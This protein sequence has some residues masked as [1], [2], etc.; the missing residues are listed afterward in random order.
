MISVSLNHFARC[1]ATTCFALVCT[2]GVFAQ[3]SNLDLLVGLGDFDRS[4]RSKLSGLGDLGIEPT[5]NCS[6][7]DGWVA[8][9]DLQHRD[10]YILKI[11]NATNYTDDGA[12]H[13][14]PGKNYQYIGINNTS[15]K[16]LLA[17]FY[18]LVASNPKIP[19]ET[20]QPGD[21]YVFSIDRL[22]ASNHSHY[23]APAVSIGVFYK[24]SGSDT[25][26]KKSISLNMS[27]GYVDKASFTLQEPNVTFV[28]P[29]VEMAVAN[30][31]LPNKVPAILI[32][33]ARL[34]VKRSGS[35]DYAAE[36]DFTVRNRSINVA[37]YAWDYRNTPTRQVAQSFDEISTNAQHYIQ[38]LQLK[39]LNPNVKVYLY[40]S[41]MAACYSDSEP[42]WA[43][44]PFKIQDAA[45]DNPGWLWP[46]SKP[47]A[48]ND[49]DT[50]A[51]IAPD[52]EWG[53]L[54]A[55]Y[56]NGSGYP[57]RFWIS[58]V[59]D[60]AYQAEWARI[61][62]DKAKKIGV[63]GVWIDD[64]ATLNGSLDRDGVWR[65]PWEVQQFLHGIIPKL[66]AAGLTVVVNSALGLLDGSDTW[67]GVAETYFNPFW[68][69]TSSRPA[70]A[71]YLENTAANTPD[72]FFR[73]Y[74]F[75]ING[76][77]YSP[78]YWLKCLNDAKIV[79]QWN[80]VLADQYKKRIHYHI[81]ERDTD[82]HPAYDRNG[83]PGWVPFVLAS[84]L[85][86]N[87]QYV[88]FCPA[89][90]DANGN[91]TAN[92]DVSITKRLGV[93]DGDDRPVDTDPYFRMRR[94]KSDGAGSF[95]GVVVVNA[96][97]AVSKTYT[98]DFGATDESGNE[99]PAGTVITLKPNSGRI[100]LKQ[101]T[102]V[103]V[104][105]VTASQN[106]VP[107]QVVDVSVICRNTSASSVNDV[108]VRAVVPD[109]TTYVPGS[110]EQSGGS[111]DAN[112]NTVSWL[113]PRLAAGATVTQTFRVTVN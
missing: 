81:G 13:L 109:K 45:R 41:G 113:V 26:H 18:S 63:D 7:A 59:A 6:L 54:I 85:L 29:Y 58:N 77:N 49:P 60:S 34:W 21:R 28:R 51:G 95:G 91:I 3:Q 107:K 73:E 39:K 14:K 46:Q 96:N 106:V 103:S 99:V 64:C 8:A 37:G 32:S 40:Q 15:G 10:K 92:I 44:A 104:Q 2:S 53:K 22:V 112:S 68:K 70:S 31:T 67:Q 1:I 88:S 98:V 36:A 57:D 62:I 72:V 94:Y 82:A 24:V 43:Y 42:F 84:F 12:V 71:G 76:F 97:T 48:K 66:R 20:F 102:T 56:L 61:V 30:N 86:C 47:K 17:Q 89:I 23:S 9:I 87:N 74:S 111:Y 27:S 33:G 105:L 83:K 101:N 69:P 55:K 78:E 52:G 25:Q 79:A 110:A 11:V 80:S 93:P 108:V 16:P 75:I 38:L 35:A 4:T 100:L 50:Y 90:I 19:A 65:H 5:E